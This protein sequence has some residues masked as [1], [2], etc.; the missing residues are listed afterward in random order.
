MKPRN[1]EDVK[2]FDLKLVRAGHPIC[3]RD[4]DE[5]H[6]AYF[7]MGPDYPLSGRYDDCGEWIQEGWTAE[8]K[9]S[10]ENEYVTDLVLAPIG[11]CADKP[12]FSGDVLISS[13]GGKFKVSIDISQFILDR[14]K[15]PCKEPAIPQ[16]KAEFT[17]DALCIMQAGIAHMLRNQLDEVID[18]LVE[19]GKVVRVQL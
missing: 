7:D 13:D 16:C 12:V 14:C 18:Y 19:S 9:T 10:A 17:E 4:G 1:K 5:A 8:G 6:I 3:Q 2:P 11:Y 15:W